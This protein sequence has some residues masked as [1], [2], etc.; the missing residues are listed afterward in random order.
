M[1]QSL[2]HYTKEFLD[3][4]AVLDDMDLE[5]ETYLGTLESFE[6]NIADK[7]ENVIKYQKEILGLAAFQKEAAKELI[8]AAKKKEKKAE[9]LTVYM[10]QAMK[11]M[12]AKTLQAGAYSLA[13][14]KGSE[15][16]MVDE[17][18]LPEKY[19]TPVV[20]RKAMSKP[21]LKK[22]VQSGTEVEGVCI[23]R[24]PDSLVIKM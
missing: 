12:N 4:K 7:M 21:E 17:D 3:V 24:N 9:A 23:V 2:Y 10:D 14:K 8:E 6:A 11:A 15:I 16:T 20:G 18:K 22:L 19:W 5:D 13:Y 1:G